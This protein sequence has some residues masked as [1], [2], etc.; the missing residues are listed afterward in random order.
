MKNKFFGYI[1]YSDYKFEELW[2]NATFVLDAN[3][4]LNLYRYSK[5]TQEK[6]IEYLQKISDR[7]WI[8]YNTAE[9]FFN[10]RTKVINDQKNVHKQIKNKINLSSVREDINKIRHT[11]LSSKKEKMLEIIDNCQKDLNRIIEDDENEISN[12]SEDIVLNKI[13]ELFSNKVGEKF[14]E[15]EL[16]KYIK[17][18]DKR[19]DKQIPPGYKDAKKPKGNRK[20][21]DCINWFEI[22]NHA[23]SNEVDIIYI[24]DDNKEDWFL[25]IEGKT[26]GPRM[27]LLQE[28]Y[29]KTNNQ[30]IYIYNTDGF[31][32]NFNKYI[33]MS[34]TLSEN[35]SNEIKEINEYNC[36]DRSDMNGKT[37]NVLPFL[38]DKIK[39]EE[40]YKMNKQFLKNTYLSL[41]LKYYDDYIRNEES[42][43]NIL[44]NEY[45]NR[46]KKDSEFKVDGDD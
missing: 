19:Y 30:K 45:F 17:I 40:Y 23:K 46:S 43:K 37:F 27:E 34:D 25:T 4:L 20:Y 14:E 18:F 31:L 39:H 13:L 44:N 15:K 8:P 42:I 29:E 21:G 3:I 1:P 11:T 26:I 36:Q 41:L 24:T 22:I 10:N 7:I 16:D 6:V 32:T 28:F 12:S 38:N 2:K 33:E 9:E 5:E 35:I